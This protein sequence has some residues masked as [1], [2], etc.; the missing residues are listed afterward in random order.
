MVPHFWLIEG[1]VDLLYCA[2]NSS[3]QLGL[4]TLQNLMTAILRHSMTCGFE[5][6]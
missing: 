4:L 1:R 2:L 3:H 5:Y 6:M